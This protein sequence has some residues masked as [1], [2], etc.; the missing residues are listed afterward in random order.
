MGNT[1]ITIGRQYGSGGRLIGR[2]LAERL[3]IS[4][5]DRE[6]LKLASDES[7]INRDLFLNADEK[8]KN[9]FLFRIARKTYNGEL[10]PP[11]SE[12]FISNDN[13]FNYQAQIIREIAA[14]ESAVIIG[15]CAD[16]ILSEH[17]S[18]LRVFIHASEQLRFER[19]MEIRQMDLKDLSKHLA[20]VDKRRSEYYRY[21]TGRKWADARNFD[22]CLNRGTLGYQA[23][24][25]AIVQQVELMQNK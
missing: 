1:I 11:D 23:C 12:D 18:V 6:L 25:D 13:L 14:N 4:Y 10:I 17:D 16:H 8:V 24:V 19:I 22:L 5:Y 2:M 15:R 20:E 21:Y 9:S 3:G 7:G